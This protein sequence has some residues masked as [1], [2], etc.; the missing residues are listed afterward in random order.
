M[1]RRMMIGNTGFKKRFINLHTW[2]S[3]VESQQEIMDYVL[4]VR[5]LTLTLR[6]LSRKGNWV[7]KK[8]RYMQLCR[9]EGLSLIHLCNE[10]KM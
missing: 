7:L 8:K 3:G 1:L 10:V 4:I 2:L 6:R 5:I 9:P